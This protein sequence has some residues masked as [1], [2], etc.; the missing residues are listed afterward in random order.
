VHFILLAGIGVEVCSLR[1]L[2]HDPGERIEAIEAIE[3]SSSLPT[4][5]RA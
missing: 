3:I 1:L 5:S 2:K 4:V